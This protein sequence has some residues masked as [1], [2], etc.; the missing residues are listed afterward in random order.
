LGADSVGRPAHVVSDLNLEL[1][2]VPAGRFK[3][4]SPADEPLRNRAEGPVTVVTLS[5]GF[6]LGKTEVTQA[7]YAAIAGVNP[8]TFASLGASAPVERV[9]WI[10]AMAYSGKLTERERAAGRLPDGYVFTLPTEAQWEYACRAGTTGA[11]AGEPDSMSWCKGNSGESTH[12]VA[13]KRPNAW[14]F[15][16]MSGNVLEWCLD[17]YADYPGG[18]VTDPIGPTRGHYR[19]ARGGSWRTD[20]RVGRSA[21]RSGGSPARLDYTLGFRLALSAAR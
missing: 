6:W 8:S 15:H 20:T 1:L 19:T 16:D 3:M 2:W 13:T 17:W 5:T 9:S 11:F 12:I 21:A 18:E 10:D 4:G 14:G 7:Q